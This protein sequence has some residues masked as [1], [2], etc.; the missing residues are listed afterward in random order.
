MVSRDVLDGDRLASGEGM[1]LG[2]DEHGLGREHR[3]EVDI[4][5]RDAHCGDDDVEFVV[6]KP[7]DPLLPG[8]R[9]NLDSGAGVLSSK[10]LQVLGQQVRCGGLA[11][12]DL[13]RVPDIAIVFLGKGVG[14]AVHALHQRHGA[15][16]EILAELRQVD[17]GP[18]APE[19]LHPEFFLKGAHL[20]RDRRLARPDPF[21]RAGNV[22]ESRR[23]AER[24]KLLEPIAPM[25]T[26]VEMLPI[27]EHV[28]CCV[29]DFRT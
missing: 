20:D 9:R 1:I 28:E 19:Q 3:V 27:V 21:C 7:L 24:A 25:F 17:A 6:A 4:R 10:P 5:G 23:V 12:S 29:S 16:V 13:E 2:G 8:T 14:E 26:L 22:P 18:V 15:F 11:G